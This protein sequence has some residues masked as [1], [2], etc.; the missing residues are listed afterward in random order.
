MYGNRVNPLSAQLYYAVRQQ[1]PHVGRRYAQKGFVGYNPDE[2]EVFSVQ[3]ERMGRW[4]HIMI[5]SAMFAQSRI[6]LAQ[7]SVDGP[8]LEAKTAE[9][10]YK[11]ITQLKGTPAE[12]VVPAMQVITSSLGVECSFCHVQG[13]PEA[14]DKPAKKTARE[15]MAM[16]ASINK[17]SFGGRQQVSCYSCHHGVA[18]P[19]SVPP[20]L[21]SDMP[22]RTENRS[23]APTGATP[24]ADDVIQKYVAAV[25]GAD[26]IRKVSS[27]IEKGTIAVGSSQTPIEVLTKAP[28]KRVTISHTSNGDSYTAFDGTAGWMGNTG[29]PAREMSPVESGA[30][31]LDAEFAI[32]LRLKEIFPQVR[33]V[34]PEQIN[35]VMC[36]SLVGTGPGRSPV[37]LY[38][39]QNSGL[40]VRMV[41]YAET[42]VGR[43]PTQIDYADYREA[44]GVKIPFRWTLSRINGRFTIQIAE[45][46]SNIAIDD[47]KFAKPTAD[48]K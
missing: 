42:P 3:M 35:G 40:L 27:R 29:R 30:S 2:L 14:D 47:A 5:V 38:F 37:R 17:G 9:Q 39:D 8:A 28:N 20:V 1:R 7:H 48:V 32:A 25:G 43:N 13:K 36:E 21:E 12:Q 19:V 4:A 11:N 31:A 45:V 34:R 23:A 18:N 6:V 24:S 44:D 33:R 15:M 26:A 41:R 22:M 46:K 16:V 10:A